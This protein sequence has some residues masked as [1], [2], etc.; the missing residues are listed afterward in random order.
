MGSV[1]QVRRGRGMGEV[2][3]I[4]CRQ[5]WVWRRHIRLAATSSRTWTGLT[6][7]REPRNNRWSLIWTD[8]AH[9]PN[10]CLHIMQTYSILYE[11]QCCRDLLNTM[12]AANTRQAF[13]PREVVK[14]TQIANP[15]CTIC[16]QGKSRGRQCVTVPCYH[17]KSRHS[18][19]NAYICFRFFSAVV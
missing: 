2:L 6:T 1:G 10:M 16:K 19:P 15:S 5:P 8:L 4:Q 17:R 12:T 7:W 11:R 18:S 14:Y 13:I 3:G 9:M